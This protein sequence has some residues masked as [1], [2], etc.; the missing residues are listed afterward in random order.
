MT[1]SIL[2]CFYESKTFCVFFA[3]WLIQLPIFLK[4]FNVITNLHRI[5]GSYTIRVNEV[6]DRH[7]DNMA[8]LNFSNYRYLLA[9]L[10]ALRAF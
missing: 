2:K 6:S 10:Y 5:T 4:T 8:Y 3:R 7:T 9:R 1:V